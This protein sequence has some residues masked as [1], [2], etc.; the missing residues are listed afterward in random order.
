MTEVDYAYLAKKVDELGKLRA[1]I[2]D[3][4]EKESEIK[5]LL[6]DSGVTEVDGNRYRATVSKSERETL[7]AEKV[8]QILT[9]G[10]LALV[11]KVSQVTAVRVCARKR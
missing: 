6:I 1:Q 9:P 2:A 11:T 5:I 8:R 10:Q 3:L 4:C 7:D